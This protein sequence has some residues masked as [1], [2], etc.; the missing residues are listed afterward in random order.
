[1][2]YNTEFQSNNNELQEI[3]N[4]IND[5]PNGNNMI[6]EHNIDINAHGD[7]FATKADISSITVKYEGNKL[8]GYVDDAWQEIV[9]KSY[10]QRTSVQIETDEVV[11]ISIPEAITSI[12]C[13][14][15]YH[16][17]LLLSE[18]INYALDTENNSIA[19]IDYTAN[20]GDVF[21]FVAH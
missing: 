14:M 2:D 21:A 15:V 18:N 12:D 3:L 11:I 17:G 1:M 4:T 9:I 10:P 19:L 16:N 7:L 5:L 8:Y 20:I 6:A 13:L